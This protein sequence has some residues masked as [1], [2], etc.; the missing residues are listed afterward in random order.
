MAIK[1]MAA[2]LEAFFT[3][4]KGHKLPHR[5]GRK[6]RC[7][8]FDCCQAKGHA[9]AVVRAAEKQQLAETSA[10]SEETM[11]LREARDRMRA[12]N[13]AHALPQLPP[14]PK[15]MG[16]VQQYLKE[17]M[18]QV[19]PLMLEMKI[20]KAMLDPSEGGLRQADD[21]LDRQGTTRNPGQTAATGGPVLILNFNPQEHSP[22]EAQV[23]PSE[24]PAR[25]A[26]AVV[27]AEYEEFDPARAGREDPE[28]NSGRGAAPVQPVDRDLD[29][30]SEDDDA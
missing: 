1:T 7:S 10:Y 19:A 26:T 4:P 17:R 11:R 2:A 22:Y 18:D 14:P 27:E 30:G 25:A 3:C 9:W 21:L 20:R 6:G 13:E 29:Q 15:R 5:R 28:S 8:P 16:T 23:R 12:W 24:L